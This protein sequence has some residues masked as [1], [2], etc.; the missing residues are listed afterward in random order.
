MIGRARVPVEYIGGTLSTIFKEEEWAEHLAAVLISLLRQSWKLLDTEIQGHALKNNLMAPA[1]LLYH[2]CTKPIVVV[3]KTRRKDE[4]VKN[5]VPGRPKQNSMFSKEEKSFIQKLSRPLFNI[6][7][8]MEN[9]DTL[10]DYLTGEDLPSFRGLVKHLQGLMSTRA[11]F[12]RR[13]AGVTMKRLIDL[14]KIENKYKLK[15]KKDMISKDIL[16]LLATRTDSYCKFA[17]EIEKLDPGY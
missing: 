7:K 3:A 14:R 6:P 4:V 5:R 9:I 17:E 2:Y 16:S 11:M 10:F 15:R 1:T 13:F 12:T 8:C